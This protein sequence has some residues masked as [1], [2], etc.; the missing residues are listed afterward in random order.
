MSAY[1]FGNIFLMD[2]YGMQVKGEGILVHAVTPPLPAPPAAAAR[3]HN[4]QVGCA[5]VSTIDRK[6]LRRYMFELRTF[7]RLPNVFG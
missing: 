4:I 7:N 2:R 3:K 5:H 1:F 6:Y